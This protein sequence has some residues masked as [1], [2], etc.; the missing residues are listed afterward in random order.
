MKMIQ[1]IEQ[2]IYGYDPSEFLPIRRDGQL[3]NKL[4]FIAYKAGKIGQVLGHVGMAAIEAMDD[5]VASSG[6]R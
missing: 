4:G 5:M 3:D 1:K 6:R 2:T